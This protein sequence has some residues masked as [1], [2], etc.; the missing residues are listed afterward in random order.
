MGHAG[1]LLGK[2]RGSIWTEIEAGQSRT[3]CPFLGGGT[4][5]RETV[6]PAVRRSQARRG[7]FLPFPT[8]RRPAW[9]CYKAALPPKT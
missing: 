7:A 5:T 1:R 2:Q 8:P 3:G 6:F 9:P 4:D